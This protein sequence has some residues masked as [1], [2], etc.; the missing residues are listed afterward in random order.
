MT[1]S[2]NPSMVSPSPW[3]TVAV[4]RGVHSSASCALRAGGGDYFVLG[5]DVLAYRT[6]YDGGTSGTLRR[7][8]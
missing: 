1:M 5:A 4:R 6:G 7:V 8:G 3:T 2:A